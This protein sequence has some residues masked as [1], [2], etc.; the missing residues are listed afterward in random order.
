MQVHFFGRLVCGY[1]FSVELGFFHREKLIK[2]KSEQNFRI[3]LLPYGCIDIIDHEINFKYRGFIGIFQLRSNSMIFPVI[4]AGGKGERFWPYSNSEHPKQV[5]PLVTKKSMLE[6]TLDH[7]K[8]LKTKAP[9]Y[10]IVSKNLE[11]PIKK[12]TK[13]NK[14]IVVIG[15]P[16]G[17]NT[18]AAIALAA[19]LISKQDPKGVMA[20]LTADHAISPSKN[21]AAALKYAAELAQKQDA[22]I[23]F[24]IKPTRPDT[25]FGYIETKGKHGSKSGI[26]SFSVKQFREKPNPAQAK[27]FVQSKKFFWNSGMFVW[28]VDYLWSLFEKNL[29]DMYK[30]F[31][32]LDKGA[33]SNAALKRKMTTIYKAI[34]P[35][36]IDYGIMEHAPNILTVVPNINWDDIGSWTALDRRHPKDK[37]GNI[38]LGQ[39]QLLDCQDVT[40]FSTEGLV[41][42]YGVKNLLIV[43][44]GAVTLVVEKDKRADLKKLVNLV[45][46]NPKYSRYL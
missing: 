38:S 14:N 22:L 3:V 41:A 29:P 25:G 7:I 8:Q 30:E 2:N 16:Q 39:T 17:R 10:V 35:Q 23:T 36:S 37:K 43:Q 19:K 15:E 33:L 1:N 20:V 5:L 32:K 11:E 9:T 45:K 27:K 44:Y 28:R 13:S 12:L 42:A 40:S 46:E 18:A 21:L 31:N 26:S 24:G 34:K 6:D 4:M